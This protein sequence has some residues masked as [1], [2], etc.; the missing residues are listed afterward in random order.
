MKRATLV[1]LL[2]LLLVFVALTVTGCGENFSIE[3][4]EHELNIWGIPHEPWH[5]GRIGGFNL[6]LNPP[7]IIFTWVAMA[8]TLLLCVTAARGAD[9]RRP[10]KLACLIEMVFDFLRGL[11]D[12]SLGP[13][14]GAGLYTLI[15]TYFLFITVANLLGLVPTAMAPTA[16]HQTTFGLAL[17]TFAMM[18]VWG[19]RYKGAKYFKHYLEPYPFF[20]PITIIEDLAKPLTLAFRLFGNMKGKEVMIVALLGLITGV[21]E[22]A[23]GFLASVLWL[24]FGVFVSFIQ[25]FVFTM[26]SIA[27]I[28]MAVS[29]EH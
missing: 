6:D 1:T 8:L 26:L 19:I 21:A 23:G 5:L 16:D 4:V 7:T 18:Y 2:G 13:K 29:E 28:S 25:A 14:K 12:E 10:S 11:V 3:R 20:L 15:F 24:A 27:Y 22:V 9:M 17:I